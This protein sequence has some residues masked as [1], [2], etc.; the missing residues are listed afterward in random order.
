MY[1]IINNNSSSI[2]IFNPNKHNYPFIISIPHSGVLITEEMNNSLNKKIILANMD[3]YLPQLYDFLENMGFTVIINNVSRYVIDPNRRLDDKSDDSAYKYNSIYTRTTFN[4]EMYTRQLEQDEIKNRINNYYIPYHMELKKQIEQKLKYFDKVYLID[5]HSFGKNIGSDIV[6]GNNY[7]KTTSLEFF[8]LIKN[9]F[10]NLGFR[11]S[12][13][14]P[15]NGGYI[16]KHYKENFSNIETLQVELWYGA[17]IDSREF[18]EEY[19][20]RINEN[21]FFFA[22]EKM[23]KVFK[24]ISSYYYINL[25]NIEKNNR[26]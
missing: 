25:F 5:M 24:N 9:E 22:R 19:K 13:N 18:G 12:D 21:T 2:Q 20:P 23:E 7:G 11:I 17:Y 15:Y 4:K 26:F 10:E 1:E 3:W 8:N 14:K 16:I 6:L